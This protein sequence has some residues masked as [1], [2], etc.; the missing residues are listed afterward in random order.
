MTVEPRALARR[1]PAGIGRWGMYEF[2]EPRIRALVADRL[3]LGLEA[4]VADASLRDDLAADSL[5]LAELALAL[6]T[7]F[8]IVLPE[9][10]LDRARTYGDL[11]HATELLIRTRDATAPV[12]A[13]PPAR[14]W[15]RITPALGGSAGILER[16]G[17]L[18]PYAAETIFEDALR[19]NGGGKLEITVATGAA[20]ALARVEDQFAPLAA[21]G[22]EVTVRGSDRPAASVRH[23]DAAT[24]ST[25]PAPCPGS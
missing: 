9:R 16:S 20:T 23:P 3:G 4:L 17:W 25:L 15:V 14:I 18:T 13:D 19:A 2:V 1:A 21:R 22:V 24:V 5:D 10:V 6:E 12:F 11:V 8:A 7:E